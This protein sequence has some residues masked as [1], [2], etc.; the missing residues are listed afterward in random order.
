MIGKKS[1]FRW[2]GVA[3]RT[4]GIMRLGFWE[5]SSSGI[6]NLAMRQRPVGATMS[7]SGAT[8]PTRL[9]LMLAG[10]PS[11]NRHH[12]PSATGTI[13]ITFSLDAT[14]LSTVLRSPKAS[15]GRNHG[16]TEAQSHFVQ[17]GLRVCK[18]FLIHNNFAEGTGC[19]VSAKA[20][21]A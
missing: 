11:S 18:N 5:T 1:A 12:R 13:H 16:D 9:C 2:P 3:T 20:K 15:R 14:R 17:K 19:I 7:A 21:L 4:M 8:L 10:T 6:P